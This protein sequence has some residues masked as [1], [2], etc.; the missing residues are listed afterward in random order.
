MK[1]YVIFRVLVRESRVAIFRAKMID[2]ALK[3]I[4]AELPPDGKIATTA[5]GKLAPKL[6][7]QVQSVRLMTCYATLLNGQP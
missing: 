5:C 7:G 6:L 1:S 2:I 4:T 3:T